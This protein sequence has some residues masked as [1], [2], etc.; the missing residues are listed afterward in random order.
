MPSEFPCVI[1][2]EISHQVISFRI[3]QIGLSI[4]VHR[5]LLDIIRDITPVIQAIV[6]IRT[7]SR[8]VQS[9]DDLHV[10]TSVHVHMRGYF[11]ICDLQHT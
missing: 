1:Q 6:S 7:E 11:L 8:Q 10:Y 5:T 2:L 3:F 4:P 9:L